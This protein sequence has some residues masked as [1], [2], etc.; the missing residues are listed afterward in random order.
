MFRNLICLFVCVTIA[1][2]SEIVAAEHYVSV[3]FSSNWSAGGGGSKQLTALPD[4]ERKSDFDIDEAREAAFDVADG[5]GTTNYYVEDLI[6]SLDYE[7]EKAFEYVRDRIA[8]D[9]Y[10]GSLR[11]EMSVLSAG[12]GNALDRAILLQRLVQDMGYDARLV[13]GELSGD[14]LDRLAKR[15]VEPGSRWDIGPLA[16]MG[17]FVPQMMQRMVDRTRRDYRWLKAAVPPTSLTDASAPD[18]RRRLKDHVWIQVDLDD[19]WTDLDPSFADSEIGDRYADASEYHVELPS[20]LRQKIRFKVVA[21]YLVADGVAED[22]SL[23]YEIDADAAAASQIYLAFRPTSVGMGNTLAEKLG[24]RPSFLPMLIVNDKNHTGSELPLISDPQSDSENFLFGSGA[25]RELTALYLDV[26]TNIP[27]E[28]GTS[29][30]RPL[31]DRLPASARASGKIDASALTAVE[32]ASGVPAPFR[33]IHQLA[34]SHGGSNPFQIAN[35][36]GLAVYFV[37]EYFSEEEIIQRM[38]VDELMWPVA[39]LRRIPVAVSEQVSVSALNDRDDLRFFIGEPRV[40]VFSLSASVET[41]DDPFSI[42]VDLLLD[43][44]DVAA[45]GNVKAADIADRQMRYG[46]IQGAFETTYLETMIAASGVQ[47]NLNSA[48]RLSTQEAVVYRTPGDITSLEKTPNGMREDL[49]SG[50]RVVAARTQ[51]GASTDVWWSVDK[52]GETRAML[53]PGLG[54]SSWWSTWGRWTNNN[55]FTGTRVTQTNYVPENMTRAEIRREQERAIRDWLKE[56]AKKKA[57][58]AYTKNGKHATRTGQAGRTPKIDRRSGAGNEYGTVMEV[59][60][61]VLET[62]VGFFGLILTATLV[63]AFI[64]IFSFIA[65]YNASRDRPWDHHTPFNPGSMG[66]ASP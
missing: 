12:A 10:A 22:V 45:S 43:K 2:P 9:P 58:K 59:A 13:F 19:G 51:D 11:G 57:D 35:D 29:R 18:I 64:V 40:Y 52:N 34:T 26:E 33:D 31:L 3:N 65:I 41:E 39:M 63:A 66:Q 16:A 30:R 49:V 28:S 42:S 44:V 62:G 56:D 7:P 50:K 6:D 61:A 5:Y 37:G 4:V 24:K 48:S 47:G 46:V 53:E 36:V 60:L 27:G 15:S 25:G 14:A 38:G 55:P 17:G 23:E 54:G 21:E 8:L 1:T 32:K 20:E